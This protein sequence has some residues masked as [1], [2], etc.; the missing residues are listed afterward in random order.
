MRCSVGLAALQP[1]RSPSQA[2][3][4]QDYLN[5]GDGV[6]ATIYI[7]QIGRGRYFAF[8]GA[9]DDLVINNTK[10]NFEPFGVM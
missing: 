4:V 1:R 3:E 6:D 9:V 8:S 10:D 5:D 2:Q 7:A